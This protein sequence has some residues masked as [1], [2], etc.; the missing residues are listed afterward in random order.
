M[1][2]ERKVTI[3]IT[4]LKDDSVTAVKRSKIE[5]TRLAIIAKMKILVT[6]YMMATLI[7]FVSIVVPSFFCKPVP[8]FF[9]SSSKPSG[10][11]TSRFSYEKSNKIPI[12]L[13]VSYIF[14][15]MNADKNAT[16]CC[17]VCVT[18]ILWASVRT[19]LN[20]GLPLFFV[21]TYSNVH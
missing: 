5:K 18:H 10:Y 7:F 14:E 8:L 4:K 11:R 17:N 12:V 13:R 19:S 21:Q 20:R 2:R 9:M 6:P 15:G 3:I 16:S 1:K